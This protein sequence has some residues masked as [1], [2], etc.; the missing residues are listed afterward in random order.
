[1]WLCGIVRNLA[2]SERRREQRRGGAAQSLDSVRDLAGSDAYPAARAVTQEEADLLWRSLAG[3]S[4]TYREPMVLFYRQ[5]QSVA[6]VARSLELAEEAGK[7]RLAR[8][9]S[10]VGGELTAIVEAN[11]DRTRPTWGFHGEGL[12]AVPGI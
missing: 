4:E 5:G 8:G 11:F 9:R 12:A 2:A 3:L 1:A 6:E 10:M 7:Q